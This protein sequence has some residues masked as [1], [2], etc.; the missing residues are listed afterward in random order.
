MKFRSK[1]VVVEAIQYFYNMPNP[2]TF[3]T[4]FSDGFGHS[5]PHVQTIDGV[6]VPIRDS[7][8]IIEEPNGKGHYPCKPEV[9]SVKYE[10]CLDKDSL[11]LI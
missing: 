2:P 1:S 6:Y 9:F 8:W 3:I 10:K 11:K 7:D 4:Y 5:V